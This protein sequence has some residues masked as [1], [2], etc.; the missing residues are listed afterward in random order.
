MWM[1][2]ALGRVCLRKHSLPGAGRADPAV[3]SAQHTVKGS[4][5]RLPK[6]EQW[7]LSSADPHIS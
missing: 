6:L 2:K 5:D 3:Q 7:S 4:Q 1:E